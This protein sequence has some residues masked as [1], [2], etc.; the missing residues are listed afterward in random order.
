MRSHCQSRLSMLIAGLLA[1]GG[2]ALTQTAAPTFEAASIKPTQA[3]GRG[4]HI[5]RGPG[6]IQMTNVTLQRCLQEAYGVTDFQISGGKWIGP[7]GY[8]IVA[9][10]PSRAAGDEGPTMAQALQALLAERFKLEI[11]RTTKDQ[12]VYLLV[13][14][15]NGPKIHPVESHDGGVDSH[16]GSMNAESITMARLADFLSTERG[17]Q[18]GHTVVDRTGLTGYYTFK[19]EWTPEDKQSADPPGTSLLSALQEQLGLK[20]EAG[21][22]PLEMLVVDHAEKPSEN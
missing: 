14:A 10:M 16:N 15:K 21:K 18:L 7:E 22:A 11:H 20:L 8:D 4:V 9:K 2:P 19:L 13:G 6:M 12:P 1:L 5:H 17:A 3:P